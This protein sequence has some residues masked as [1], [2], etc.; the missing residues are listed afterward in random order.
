MYKKYHIRLIRYWKLEICNNGLVI[1]CDNFYIFYLIS[2]L[3]LAVYRFIFL[4][5]SFCVKYKCIYDYKFKL[6]LYL[7]M[8]NHGESTYT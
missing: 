8:I 3:A 2:F 6:L 1:L 7:N 5:F 4:N